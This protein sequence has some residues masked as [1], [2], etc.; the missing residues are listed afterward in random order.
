MCSISNRTL[1]DLLPERD[2]G[3]ALVSKA[4]INERFA[5]KPS[6][7]GRVKLV[8]DRHRVMITVEPFN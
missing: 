4:Q 3:Y 2:T 1:A 5:R 6:L 8:C 7:E